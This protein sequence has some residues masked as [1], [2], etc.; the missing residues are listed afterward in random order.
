MNFLELITLINSDVRQS[1]SGYFKSFFNSTVRAVI[2]YRINAYIYRNWSTK[3][4]Y[5]LHNRDRMKYNV[6]IYPAAKIGKGFVLAHLGAIVIG[7]GVVIGHDCLYKV[8]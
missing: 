8:E 7:D 4:A 2:S 3:L 6:D 5:I 1:G